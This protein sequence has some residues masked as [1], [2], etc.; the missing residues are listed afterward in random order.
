MDEGVEGDRL[1]RLA[2]PGCVVLRREVEN[3][4][5]QDERMTCVQQRM[6]WS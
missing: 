3:G 1:K 2:F 6:G 4:W 5:G